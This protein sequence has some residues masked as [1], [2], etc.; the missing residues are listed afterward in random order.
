MNVL[1]LITT[2]D[3]AGRRNNREHQVIRGLGP[4][5]DRVVVVFRRRTATRRARFHLLGSDVQRWRD[6][7]VT[8]VA[9]DPPL[10]PPEGAVRG[11]TTARPGAGPMRR[12]LGLVL[13][14]AA[15]LRDRATITAL[16]AASAHEIQ[17]LPPGA[18]IT[19][20]AF[21]PWAAEAARRLRAR[22][23]LTA[24]A[25]VDRDYEPGFLASRPRRAWAAAMERRAARSADLTLSIGQR[26]AARH[27]REAGIT[28][29]LSPTGVDCAFFHGRPRLLSPPHLVYVGEV[30][31]W[32]CIE[33]AM[34]A[35]ADP[36]LHAARMTVRGPALPGFRS[37]LERRAMALGLGGRFDW[38]GDV[39]RTQIPTVLQAATLG[40]CVFQ[41]TALRIHAAPLKLLEYMASGLPSLA[42]HGSEAGDLVAR[43][44]AGGL[45]AP[46]PAS[47]VAAVQALH[48]DA[49]AYAA[50]SRA[51]LETAQAMDWQQVLTREGRL[52]TSMGAAPRSLRRAEEAP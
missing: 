39:P 24:Y 5:Y 16:A 14:S 52:L 19:C 12:A 44:G 35:L 43:S 9:V 1:L 10:N 46:D 18:A 3:V 27:A 4:G 13:D 31:P 17:S 6:G 38:A 22:G 33:P 50:L 48:S 2:L 20:E 37:H 40:F 45:C 34:E 25:Y 26:L 32:S 41:P 30:A 11:K 29:V 28:A 15:I 8:Y 23:H 51:A 36:A 49:D 42:V 47:I 7:T 21:G